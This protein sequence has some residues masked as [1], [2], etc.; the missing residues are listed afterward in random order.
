[1]IHLIKINTVGELIEEI[2][3]H[4]LFMLLDNV[5][6]SHPRL[7]PYHHVNSFFSSYELGRDVL[8]YLNI[9]KKYGDYR[10]KKRLAFAKY[11]DELTEAYTKNDFDNELNEIKSK[12]L[13]REIR[14]NRIY[15]L[16]GSSFWMVS[17]AYLIFK[18]FN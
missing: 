11:E 13:E 5:D 1:M 2:G 15:F 8:K 3:E 18:H 9:V 4:N 6:D 12:A 7:E 16:S 17:A 10:D 14:L